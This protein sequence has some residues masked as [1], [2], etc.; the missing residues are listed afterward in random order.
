MLKDKAECFSLV[1]QWLKEE[2]KKKKEHCKSY[3][4]RFW[5]E[6]TEISAD[7]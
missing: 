2:K 4:V 3:F 1:L 7:F 6:T 5:K